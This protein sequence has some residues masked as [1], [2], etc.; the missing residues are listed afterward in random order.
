MKNESREPGEMEGLEETVKEIEEH[1][2][3]LLTSTVTLVEVLDP[4]SISPDARI[5]FV[6]L[7]DRPNVHTIA[8]DLKVAK[9]A[10]EIRRYYRKVGRSIGV[11][12]SIHLASAITMEVGEFHTFDKG[13]YPLNGKVMSDD[14]VVHSLQICA[15][16]QTQLALTS[17]HAEQNIPEAIPQ[18]PAK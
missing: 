7:F 5:Q 12:D 17:K 11:P 4:E 15:P 10:G 14:A 3:S 13:L 1:K 6:K 18:K 2:A 8:L 9:L 16:Y